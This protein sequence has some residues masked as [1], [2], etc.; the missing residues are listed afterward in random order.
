MELHSWP[1][2]Q[3]ILRHPLI[4]LRT[5]S[6]G[7]AS[8][9]IY[10]PPA[11]STPPDSTILIS[12]FSETDSR[13]VDAHEYIPLARWNFDDTNTW[14]GEGG[15]WPLLTNNLA[16][17]PS[18]SSNAVGIDSTNSTL[19]AYRVVETNGNLNF[20]CQTGSLVFYFKPDWSSDDES[21]WNR[22]GEFR[23]TD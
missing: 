1:Q 23:P 9:W 21:G 3:S 12:A 18:W 20:N 14:V 6:N 11:D 13:S 22:A 16:G 7:M 17:V 15:Q 4:S 8:V 2:I 5:D 19:L 10:F